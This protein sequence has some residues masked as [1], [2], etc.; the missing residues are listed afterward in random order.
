MSKTIHLPEEI[1]EPEHVLEIFLQP[2]EFYWGDYQTRIRTMLGSCIAISMWHPRRKVGGLS[3]YLLP[4]RK[5]GNQTEP[6]SG[7]YAD[8]VIEIF[9]NE[10]KNEGTKAR[11]Y[12]V[13]VFGGSSLLTRFTKNMGEAIGQ[14][15]IRAAHELLRKHNF[16]IVSEDTGSN[17]YRKIVFE[18]WNGYVWVNKQPTEDIF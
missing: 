14:S 12:E 10:I 9:L 5:D 2:G 11:E 7:R 18:L 16:N 3:H 17:M 8:E 1:V 6:L 15:N 4:T 13:K